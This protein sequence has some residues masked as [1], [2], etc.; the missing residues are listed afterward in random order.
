MIGQFVLW[1]MNLYWYCILARM[2]IGW[3]PDVASMGIGRAIIRVTEPYLSLFRRFIPPVRIG[4]GY[5][6]LSLIV[7]VIAYYFAENGL[8]W[9][10]EYILQLFG[11]S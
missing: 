7:A 8:L 4:G 5:L 1:V 3:F 11:L 9:V 10:L 6:D 2:L